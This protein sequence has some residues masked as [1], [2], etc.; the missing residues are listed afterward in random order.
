[1]FLRRTRTLLVTQ[2]RAFVLPLAI[3]LALLLLAVAAVAPLRK[4]TVI[5]RMPWPASFTQAVTT[6]NVLEPRLWRL[7][8]IVSLTGSRTKDELC[9]ALA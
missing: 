4:A 9:A 5:P 6:A 2:P 3:L 7:A 8:D 1:M